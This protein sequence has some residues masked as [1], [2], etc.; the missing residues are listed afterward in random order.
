MSN[1]RLKNETKVPEIARQLPAGLELGLRNYWYP[2]LRSEQLP[3][4]R[5]LGFKAL[6]EALVA[7]RDAAG[8]PNVVRDKCP[9]RGV[10]LSA[11]RIL[12]GDLQC[13][14]HGLRFNGAGECTLI[15]WEPETSPLLKEA[16]TRGY[17][18]QE[19][20]GWIW[21]YIGESDKFAPPPLEDSVPEE[22]LHPDQFIM[23]PAPPEVWNAN[24][25]QAL[26]GSDAF[27]AVMLH[28]DSQPVAGSVVVGGPVTRPAVPLADRRMKIVDTPQGI[29]GVAIDREGK[30]LHH[31]H[32]MN[33]WKGERWT[34]PGMFSIPLVPAP[35][36]P[37][38]VSRVYQFAI[39]ATHTQSNRWVTMRATTGEERAR[40]E[41]LWKDV[42]W[43]R[44]EKVMHEDKVMIETLGDL[45]ESR[46]EEY[47]FRADQDTL[48]VRRMMS[49][50]YLAQLA[51]TRPTHS[52]DAFV[53]P[54]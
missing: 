47:L 39:D 51:G 34:L 12:N 15:P 52:R 32:F 28:S 31:G 5:P 1:T 42:I 25:L 7:W 43:P 45:A 11:G 2:V 48:A 9:H 13:A 36:L 44:Y 54:F 23:F 3:A 19:L 4:D 38:Y 50:A 27:H 33:G 29:R 21:T 8:R 49:D 26:D 30:P 20:G 10:K 14:W 22:L 16:C 46:S 18:T 35:N 6:N 41:Q 40:C 53:F 24:W 37:S 17:P